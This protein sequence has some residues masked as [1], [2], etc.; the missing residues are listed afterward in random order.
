V[1]ALREN[2]M[3]SFPLFYV[4]SSMDMHGMT[5]FSFSHKFSVDEAYCIYNLGSQC[6][7]PSINI[8]I[9]LTIILIPSSP[10]NLSSQ[11]KK[12]LMAHC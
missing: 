9:F 1:I 5:A 10:T 12:N 8:A 7:K 11:R 3:Q 2:E 6:V 4:L